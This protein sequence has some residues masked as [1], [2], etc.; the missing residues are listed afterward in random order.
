[1]SI[2]LDSIHPHQD[3]EECYGIFRS[4]FTPGSLHSC[5]LLSIST[6]LNQGLGDVY[7]VTVEQDPV[8]SQLLTEA[9]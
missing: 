4:I 5:L 2:V 9:G 7:V 3:V 8:Y 6:H 1:M